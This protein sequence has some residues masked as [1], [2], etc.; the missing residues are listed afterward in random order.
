[1]V[2]GGSLL[3][4]VVGIVIMSLFIGVI[5]V[6]PA[7]TSA[8]VRTGAN[9]PSGSTYACDGLRVGDDCGTSAWTTC[10]IDNYNICECLP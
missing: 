5:A 2:K 6:Q 9:C 7:G 4:A 3:Y 10:Q 8:A 1:M